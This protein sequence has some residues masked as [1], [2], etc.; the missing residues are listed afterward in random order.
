[1]PTVQTIWEVTTACALV[2]MR[3]LDSMKTAA[4]SVVNHIKF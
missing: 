4:V 2:D 1:M 3:D